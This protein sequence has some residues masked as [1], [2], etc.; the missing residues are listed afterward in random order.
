MWAKVGLVLCVD[1]EKTLKNHEHRIRRLGKIVTG[2]LFPLQFWQEK[3]TKSKMG[4][5]TKIGKYEVYFCLMQNVSHEIEPHLKQALIISFAFSLRVI[6]W[7]V[8]FALLNPPKDS[9]RALGSQKSSIYVIR[10]EIPKMRHLRTRR[11]FKNF[12]FCWLSFSPLLLSASLSWASGLSA[13]E[14]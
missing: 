4:W 14:S 10:R 1:L 9:R 5:C 7:R 8:A 12:P 2:M 13:T 3:S 11:W 6:I